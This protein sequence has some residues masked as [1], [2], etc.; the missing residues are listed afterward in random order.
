MASSIEAQLKAIRASIPAAP[1]PQRGPQTRPSILYAPKEAA[2]I[3]LR[4]ILPIALSGLDILIEMDERFS[5]YKN[6]LFSQTT[7]ELDREQMNQK[8]NDKLNKS[9][10]SY[11]RLISGHLLHL[12]ARKTV[13]YLIRRYLVHIYNMEELI[14]CAFPYHDT[15]VFVQIVQLIKPG[16]T[17]WRF[18]EGVKETGAAPPRHT[19]V[20]QCLRDKGLL[21]T[22][23]N[24][25]TGNKELNPSKPVVSFCTAVIVESLGQIQKLD[26]DIVRR[27]LDFV[28]KALDHEN[29]ADQDHKSGAL[30]VIGLL[31][32]KATLS[33]DFVQKLM[34]SIA[35]SALHDANESLDLPWLRVTTMA[36][37]SLVQSQP[38]RGLLRKS[39]VMILKQIRDFA[40]VLSELSNQYN[41]QRFINLYLESLLDFSN[42]DESCCD[43]LVN[44]I[45]T[46]PMKD[47]VEKI[48][49]K[50]LTYCAKT[51]KSSEKSGST[52]T[53]KWAKKILS[54][55]E[56][57]YSAEL[58][59]AIRKFLQNNGMKLKKG[60][61]IS[62]TLSLLFDNT[63]ENTIESNLWFYLESPKAEV[64][65]SA[66]KK[67]S[68]SGLIKNT[69]TKPHEIV[70]L[71]DA[72]IRGLSDK[73]LS[74]V[75]AALS[76][77]G[78]SSVFNSKSLFKALQNVLFRCIDII[79]KGDSNA[80]KASDVAISCLERIVE[81]QSNHVNYAKD[82]SSTI[83]PL[84]IIRSKTWKLNVK[85]L[86]LIKDIK[87][88][89]FSETSFSL[90]PITFN[91]MKNVEHKSVAANN[92]KMIEAFSKTFVSNPKEYIE[93]L[94]E[95][96]KDNNL[97]RCL[98]F[99]I[100][101][102]AL[103]VNNQGFGKVMELCQTC[104]VYLKSEWSKIGASSDISSLS[105]EEVEKYCAELANNLFTTQTEELNYKSLVC[106]FWSL[107][108]A[109]SNDSQFNSDENSKRESLLEDLFLFFCSAP[110]KKNPFKIHL[111][112]LLINC[113][114]T[115]FRFLS[116]Y[117]SEEGFSSE[118][119]IESLSLYASL[120]SSSERN[121]FDENF[122]CELLV[123]LPLILIPL[124]H[125]NKDIRTSAMNC[126][127]SLLTVWRRFS[128]SL[129]RNG[130][131]SKVPQCLLSPT[132][133]V[134]LE[135][136]VDQKNMIC[137]DSEF[138]SSYLT[139][140]LSSSYHDLI[141][142]DEIQ[143]RFDQSAKDSMLIF[144]LNSV[145]TFSSYG[146]LM[147]LSLL[148]GMG[149]TLFKVENVK[150]FFLNLIEKRS[151]ELNKLTTLEIDV[152]CLLLEVSLS[153]S[154]VSEIDKDI[155]DS[156]IRVVRVDNFSS[157]DPCIIKPI[158]AI[159]QTI[160]PALF[161]SLNME[162]QDKLFG[163][164][165]LLL[166]N[167]NTQIRNAA[168][169]TVKHLNI[170]YSTIK[171]LIDVILSRAESAEESKRNKRK[172]KDQTENF[173]GLFQDSSRKED[174]RISIL[175]SLLDILLL[176]KD[177]VK[178][179]NLVKPVLQV[180]AALFDTN[181]IQAL[182]SQNEN[183]NE[184]NDEE[185]DSGILY[186]ARQLAL[187]V[188]KDI[189]DSM[190][191][192]LPHE[193]LF[194]K[195]DVDLLI[196]CARSC[197][198]A[199]TRNHVFTLVSSVSRVSPSLVSDSI[200][201]IFSVIGESA[202]KQDDSHSQHVLE[203]LIS[204]LI[205][206]WLS[207]TTSVEELLQIFITALPDLPEH[208]R[209]ML[210]VYLSRTL[211]E[212]TSL[213][214]IIY[215]LLNS[216]SKN[217]LE[218]S[219]ASSESWEFK[220]ALKLCSQYSCKIWFPSL[221]NLLKEVQSHEKEGQFGE[222]FLAVRFVLDM[223]RDTELT[224]EFESQQNSD[225]LQVTLGALMEQIVFL[226]QLVISKKKQFKIDSNTLNEFHNLVNNSL[227]AITRWM[228]PST[229]FT[230]MTRLIGDQNANIQRKT[231]SLLCET[232]RQENPAQKKKARKSKHK[233]LNSLFELDASS[234]ESFTNL[235]TKL[236]QLIDGT[237]EINSENIL[238]KSSSISSLE[239]LASKFPSDIYTLSLPSVANQIVSNNSVIC[240]SAIRTAGALI[241]VLGPKALP[242]LPLIMKNTINS[243]VKFT[244]NDNNKN[245]EGVSAI[246]SSVFATLEVIVEKLGGFLNPYLESILELVLLRS[247]FYSESDSKLSSKA[248]SLRKLLTDKIPVRLMLQ[249]ILQTYTKAI[250]CGEISLSL[251]FEMLLSLINTMDRASI[252]T[253]HAKIFEFCL[254]SLNLRHETPESIKNVNLVENSVIN[255]LTGLTMRLTEK[256]F[257]PLF[258]QSF[259]WAET[260]FDFGSKSTKSF[261]RAIAFYK[262]VNMLSE[263]HR[264]LF[265]PYFKY[266]LESCVRYLS[267][268]SDSDLVVLKRKKKKAKSSGDMKINEEH[269]NDNIQAQK[270]WHV[271][272]LVVN[273]LHKC[274]LYDSDQK[275]L[276]S[277]NFEV[278]LKPV[279]AQLALDLPV[280]LL[281]GVPTGEEMDESLVRC[282][283]QMAVTARSDV[284]WKPLNHEVLMQTRNEKLRPKI[285]GLKIIRYLVQSLK[286][287]YMVFLP[288]TIPFL[289][290]LLEDAELSVKSLA[291]E[292]LKEMETLS[293]ESLRQYL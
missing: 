75:Q 168:R 203:N 171:R 218:P 252:T 226:L 40:A 54:V 185:S 219:D 46:V 182:F 43:A 105:V 162:T 230:S 279:V 57:H 24:Y 127:E 196:E 249:P 98:F 116:K 60:E 200:I 165:V 39:V 33:H 126:V 83:F 134:F 246:L 262:F 110:L 274:F 35:R 14:L 13:E 207:K 174:S 52:D 237:S 135:A 169:G 178:R 97:S 287:E 19:I 290:E 266:L 292:V 79:N 56:K 81:F 80:S 267:G 102:R 265:V 32:T 288:E 253:Y 34:L 272:Y 58:R 61:S 71:Q 189:V 231:L 233:P 2:D 114:N 94:V 121:N 293:G 209:L 10:N 30:M 65:K 199:S 176:K 144:F 92:K 55:I 177:L 241:T 41:I 143:D 260:E 192:D 172:K 240:S 158:V 163:A 215:L 291:Q 247:K 69:S 63:E 53:G 232:L 250:K 17:K 284:L 242:Q 137:S 235:V 213:G 227:K 37:I 48:A 5:R 153:A 90:D 23:C 131:N 18:L 129:L 150:R 84:L 12:A 268:D 243:T 20:Q 3:D 152:L 161:D 180:L 183:A 167:E 160:K 194:E 151:T 38:S 175:T 70:N 157:E 74:V 229:F 223:M 205:P 234:S 285:L 244:E 130:S 106:T 112:F 119:Q 66:M 148:K 95:S 73:D 236:V 122:H 155:L 201:D 64:R 276:D 50:V 198:D 159:L 103:L 108:K 15:H 9:I 238:I 78:I 145:L 133:G 132:F 156:V 72:V 25:G 269:N 42:S 31:G 68:E 186:Q 86:E 147:V 149:N 49:I 44:I 26:N 76:I 164:F 115:P 123:G 214:K 275:I 113:T 128:S 228:V 109:C 259:E 7:L 21:E 117:F 193:E 251:T 204:T 286:E 281:S 181:S 273:A 67:I 190:Q 62:E 271:K 221:V 224:F 101:L 211:G 142:P 136:L 173:F 27:V 210:I 195:K 146:K 88:G 36:M 120:G 166:R 277:S 179:V 283:G 140:M 278:L 257:R 188:L 47:S 93:W 270:L 263:Q 82:V 248:S 28:L 197:S 280:D 225:Y 141:I 256:M 111:Q 184:K 1:E 212:E 239:L 258:L 191:L 255:A 51:A 100:V 187:L 87:W 208:R 282:L 125:Q 29:K 261:D 45:E 104:F 4:S 89:L 118:V 264:S 202:L 206:C 254:N 91:Q 154:S 99:L 11:F 107:L 85:A 22:I 170:S 6:T 139:A 138:L 8:E 245:G 77:E 220:L 124:S 96:A 217:L 222:I 216:L 59:G 16:N 289:G